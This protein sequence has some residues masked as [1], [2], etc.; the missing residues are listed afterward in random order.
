EEGYYY[1]GD[2]VTEK[3]QHSYG[4]WIL[5]VVYENEMGKRQEITIQDGYIYVNK[6]DNLTLN[7]DLKEMLTNKVDMT[8]FTI[9]GDREDKGDSLLVNGEKAWDEYNAIDDFFNGFDG[10][11]DL[12]YDKDTFQGELIDGNISLDF[13][14]KKDIYHPFLLITSQKLKPYQ[15]NFIIPYIGANYSFFTSSW[16]VNPAPRKEPE[17][18]ATQTY[19]LKFGHERRKWRAFIDLSQSNWGNGQLQTYSVGGDYIFYKYNHLKKI[20]GPFAKY[21][22]K[23]LRPYVG[24]SLGQ[25]TFQT[26]LIDGDNKKD[27]MTW[28]IHGGTYFKIGAIKFEANLRYVHIDLTVTESGQTVGSNIPFTH[29]VTF[30]NSI[31]TTLGVSF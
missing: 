17:A 8:L 27:G 4:G 3:G 28:E 31:S 7:L 18:E 25:T 14:T 20:L 21:T 2:L 24:G 6:K 29:S 15:E 23:H 1:I 22:N 30:K 12:S 5:V 11:R 19:G 26:D 13:V 16:S 10:K 9:D